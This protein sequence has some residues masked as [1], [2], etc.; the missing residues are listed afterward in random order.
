MT[1]I[2]TRQARRR[3]RA[4]AAGC[5]IA[6]VL[7]AATQALA[8]SRIDSMTVFGDSY[9]AGHDNIINFAN[10]ALYPAPGAAPAT[11]A[12]DRFVTFPYFVQRELGIANGAS[13]NYAIP[14]S[15]TD[16][17]NVAGPPL[18]LPFQF[19]AWRDRPF[20]ARELV[21]LSIG[22]NDGLGPSG[23]ARLA[24]GYGP[25][26]ANFG[27]A[28]ALAVAAATADRELAAID[29]LV[30]AGA[31]T[32]ALA[33]FT[34]LTAIPIATFTPHP[35]SSTIYSQALYQRLQ[36]GLAPVAASGVRVFLSDG[37]RLMQ[38]VRANLAAYGFQ[39]YTYAPGL[40]SYFTVDQIHLTSEGMELSAKYIVNRL[41]APDTVAAQAETT[42]LAAAAFSGALLQ[43]L[44][45]GG[46]DGVTVGDLNA[47]AAAAQ[48][49]PEALSRPSE[50]A[51]R[52]TIFASAVYADTSRDDQFGAYGFDGDIAGV[53][54]GV[55]HRLSD[56]V[57]VGLA[58]GYARSDVDLNGRA[59]EVRVDSYQLGAY[60]GLA[61][62]GW[63]VE[64]AA[65][66]AWNDL[67]LQRGGVIDE[68]QGD[69][70]GQTITVAGQAGRLFDLGVI[71][72][73]PIFGLSYRRSSVHPYAE[74]GD[75][76]LVYSVAQ[77]DLSSMV[78]SAGVE[79]RVPLAHGIE[80]Y[81]DLTIEQE[82]GHDLRNVRS[83]SAQAPLLPITSQVPA[84]EDRTFGRIS[85]G[86]SAALSSRMWAAADFSS[87]IGRNDAQ[88]LRL[89]A[90]LGLAF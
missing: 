2:H 19:A 56:D 47:R 40:K 65:T 55:D 68:I 90:R 3:S 42:Q 51:E 22:G 23:G 81:V 41:V 38:Q 49:R 7:P 8:Q 20:S 28:E 54:F 67:K 9:A 27:R 69:T 62:N 76:L 13:R 73:G 78:A 39:S 15:T 12:S 30:R 1:S 52:T 64:G 85:A 21:I 70:E 83:T 72:T 50:A 35:E 33:S 86:V 46:R 16:V 59:G 6:A 71:R 10:P 82:F 58:A 43:R 57:R 80:P 48:G 60:A 53:M 17:F 63:F 24:L 37:T 36:Q 14:G 29:R 18:S 45:S 79:V 87:T 77:D 75:A 88:D 11:L 66:Y 89:G 34:D 5:A 61:R 31:R 44:R 26:G 25:D 84:A 74:K 32:L 4:L